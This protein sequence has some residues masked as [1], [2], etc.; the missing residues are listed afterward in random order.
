MEAAQDTQKPERAE[1]K[2]EARMPYKFRTR[3]ENPRQQSNYQNQPH[4]L[5]KKTGNSTKT[6]TDNTTGRKH[7][8]TTKHVKN[9]C[10]T[11]PSYNP[12]AIT[13]LLKAKLN[14]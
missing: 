9:I 14:N 2:K 5:C 6:P 7:G 13:N 1:T 11:P 10:K 12:Y 3:E 4:Q 8:R